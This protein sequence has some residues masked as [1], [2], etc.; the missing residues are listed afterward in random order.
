ME[1]LR[2]GEAAV[3]GLA[4]HFSARLEGAVLEALRWE[5]SRVTAYDLLPPG[6]EEPEL[7]ARIMDEYL[8]GEALFDDPR[9]LLRRASAARL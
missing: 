8:R 7:L 5:V 3:K 1:S 4:P 2:L 6:A 9:E